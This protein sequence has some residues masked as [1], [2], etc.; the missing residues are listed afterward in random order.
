[1]AAFYMARIRTDDRSATQNLILW[2]VRHVTLSARS[3][4]ID[5][6]EGHSSCRELPCKTLAILDYSLLSFEIAIDLSRL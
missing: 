4:G 3:P 2:C 6:I 5:V 1:M